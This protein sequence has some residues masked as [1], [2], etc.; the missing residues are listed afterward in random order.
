M[1]SSVTGVCAGCTRVSTRY[2]LGVPGHLPDILL[3]TR[4]PTRYALGPR[5]LPDILRGY[6]GTYPI[7]LGVPGDPPDILWGYP[8]TY[9]IYSGGTRVPTRYALGG[10]P[11]TYPICSGGTRVSTRYTLGVPGYLPEYDQNNQIWYL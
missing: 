2:A 9:P 11:G 3:V 6:P 5:Y 4:V 8:G 1:F 10:Y 7:Y